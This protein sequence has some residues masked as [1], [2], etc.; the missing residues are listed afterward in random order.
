MVSKSNQALEELRFLG[1]INKYMSKNAT[2]CK[3]LRRTR[4]V[5]DSES[6]WGSFIGGQERFLIGDL[7]TEI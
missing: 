5:R 2:C 6:D 7:R 3:A 4:Q 1:K